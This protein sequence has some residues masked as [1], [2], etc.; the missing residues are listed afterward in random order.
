MKSYHLYTDEKFNLRLPIVQ[1][2]PNII[3]LQMASYY[4]VLRF[5]PDMDWFKLPNV[6][7]FK[8]Y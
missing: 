6:D 4:T 1:A 5:N 7:A 2:I 3:A 8:I